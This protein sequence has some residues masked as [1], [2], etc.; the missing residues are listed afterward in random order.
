MNTN[1]KFRAYDTV[2]K[3]MGY[4]NDFFWDDEYYTWCLKQEYTEMRENTIC[5]VPI[6]NNIIFMYSTDFITKEGIEVYEDDIVVN[7]S[8][9]GV[10]KYFKEYGQFGILNKNSTKPVG[11]GG[12]S[13][14]YSPYNFKSYRSLKV[15][16]NIHQNLELLEDK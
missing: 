5:N 10:I 4:F 13:T 12:S 3:R 2:G 1:R 6:G 14:R 8:L 9:K 15:I 11:H 16:G 7:G